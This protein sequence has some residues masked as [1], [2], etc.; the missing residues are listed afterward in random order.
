MTT[1]DA[2]DFQ[3]VNDGDTPKEVTKTAPKPAVDREG[4]ASTQDVNAQES[5]PPDPEQLEG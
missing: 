3:S 5:T 4:Q 2:L 1:K